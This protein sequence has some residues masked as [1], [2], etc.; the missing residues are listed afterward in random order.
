MILLSNRHTHFKICPP[1]IS[2]LF[3]CGL[4]KC[5]VVYDLAFSVVVVFGFS[6]SPTKEC[7]ANLA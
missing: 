3:H 5:V 7:F 4:N 1:S 6:D 2:I